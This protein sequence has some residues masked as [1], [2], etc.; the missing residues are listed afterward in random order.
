MF[1][2]LVLIPMSEM[3]SDRDSKGRFVPGNPGGPGRP[4]RTVEQD[5][6]LALSEAVTI[7]KWKQIVESAVTAAVQGDDKARTW[8]S[9]Y[10]LGDSLPGLVKLAAWE[11]EGVDPVEKEQLKVR[12]SERSDKRFREVVA[13]LYPG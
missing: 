3:A 10:L 7:E 1:T 13:S 5:Y 4:R 6:L 2:E 9:K 8:L 12:D 11:A